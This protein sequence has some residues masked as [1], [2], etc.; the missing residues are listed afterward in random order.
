MCKVTVA[1]GSFA[2]GICSVLLFGFSGSH[3]STIVQSPSSQAKPPQA[4]P[5]EKVEMKSIVIVRNAIPVV[6]ALPDADLG[7]MLIHDGPQTLDGLN[8]SGCKFKNVVFSY[9]GGPTRLVNCSFEGTIQLTLTGAAANTART[10]AYLQAVSKRQGPPPLNPNLP[11]MRTTIFS[12]P[13]TG[14][15]IT[16]FGQ[17]K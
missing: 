16:P 17:P 10:V 5:D 12:S 13:F 8:C 7:D 6:P 3:T 9:G 15:L 14:D 2:L 1:L 11:I 4:R